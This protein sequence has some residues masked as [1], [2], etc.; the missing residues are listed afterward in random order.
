MWEFR[1]IESLTFYAWPFIDTRL[2]E[3]QFFL[4]IH[5]LYS[6]IFVAFGVGWRGPDFLLDRAPFRPLRSCSKVS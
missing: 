2:M 5:S 3:T 4:S 6:Y 1:L